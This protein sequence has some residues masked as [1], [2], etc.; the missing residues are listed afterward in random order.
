MTSQHLVM[1]IGSCL[2]LILLIVLLFKLWPTQ[3]VDI[4]RQEMFQLR[5]ELFD[6]AMQGEVGFDDPAYTLL[7]QLMNGF[8]RYAHN[9][10]PFRVFFSFFLRRRTLPGPSA[11]DWNVSW[12]AALEKI[13]DRD[14]R[15]RMEAFHSRTTSLV[16]GQLIFSP[17]LVLTLIIPLMAV[18]LLA[19]QIINLKNLYGQIIHRI[20]V[21]FL[22]EEATS[23]ISSAG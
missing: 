23:L 10:T 1:I 8:I 14:K 20:P 7:R 18:V 5:D 17:G 13:P 15:N 19:T 4:F 3:R 2:T 9:L 21:D 6:F 12:K 22:Q 16:I 11:E